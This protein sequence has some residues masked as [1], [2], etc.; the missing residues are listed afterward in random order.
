[1]LLREWL[2][3]HHSSKTLQLLSLSIPL[4]IP[5]AS[6][7]YLDT[8][9]NNTHSPPPPSDDNIPLGV[10]PTP[11]HEKSVRLPFFGFSKIVV[12]GDYTSAK[13]CACESVGACL[14]RK[15]S[16]VKLRSSNAAI[17]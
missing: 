13:A 6:I 16:A 7:T 1:M 2:L 15:K 12:N 11:L 14:E 17:M 3:N 4:F 8:T 10:S 5:T 9:A